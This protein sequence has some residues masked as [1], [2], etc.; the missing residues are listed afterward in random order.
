MYL[1]ARCQYRSEDFLKNCFV[2]KMNELG[3]N[4]IISFSLLPPPAELAI[5]AE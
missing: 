5:L 1:A 4:S 2:E 3:P